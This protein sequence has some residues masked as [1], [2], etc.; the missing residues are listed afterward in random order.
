VRVS[1]G[2]KW[3]SP[4]E[5][6]Q[7]ARAVATLT[8]TRTTLDGRARLRA[9]ALLSRAALWKHAATRARVCSVTHPDD[10]DLTPDERAWVDKV[11]PLW[12]RAHRIV[13]R[14]PELDVSDVFHVLRNLERSPAERLR[15]A[16]TY[17]RH[18]PHRRRA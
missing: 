3:R 13:S 11:E 15:R 8:A 10:G 6:R 2:V 4:S 18:H 12:R 1:K 9:L 7:P 5:K 16:L 14:H 17:G